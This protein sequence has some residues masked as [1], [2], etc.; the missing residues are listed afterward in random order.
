MRRPSCATAVRP[1]RRT[2]RD[3]RRSAA[4]PG[5]QRNRHS[6][7]APGPRPQRAGV[8]PC[9]PGPARRSCRE[10]TA[11]KST[12]L[13]R[14]LSGRRSCAVMYVVMAAGVGPDTICYLYNLR[15]RGTELLSPDKGRTHDRIKLRALET[16]PD[17]DYAFLVALA[18]WAGFS[19]G[20]RFFSPAG[21]A[22]MGAPCLQS[23]A[24][25]KR[26]LSGPRATFKHFEQM[27]SSLSSSQ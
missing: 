21:A 11:K 5:T 23:T 7:A 12:K 17:P 1:M 25:A 15:S 22:T 4:H 18:F 13:K 24:E 26:R 8:L 10:W 6:G 9:V 19:S 20:L 14:V 27:S 3:G 2:A 16:V